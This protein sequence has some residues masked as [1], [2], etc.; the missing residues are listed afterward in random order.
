MKR[1][2]ITGVSGSNS[3]FVI[4]DLL[5]KNR[6]CLIVVSGR[7]RAE[8]LA[9]DLSFFSERR[10]LIIPTEDDVFFRY[11]AK[12]NDKEVE[13]TRVL[14][15]LLEDKESVVIV[16]ASSA[17]R[18]LPPH[19][20]FLGRGISLKRGESVEL[21]AIKESL[22]EMGYER[23][24][25]AEFPGRFA[26]RGG[27]LDIYPLDA[28]EP[29]RI[30]FF[31]TEVDSI[32]TFDP[33]S[34]RS[35]GTL[36]S[37]SINPM[38]LMSDQ[39]I[40]DYLKG[41]RPD[42]EHIW[43]YMIDGICVV[44][45]PDRIRGH[46]ELTEKEAFNDF[47][48]MLERG[49][50]SKGDEKY[51]V[52]REEL[53][54]LYQSEEIYFL[55]PFA[56]THPEEIVLTDNYSLSARPV[57]SYNGHLDVLAKDIR[58]YIADGYEVT[59]SASSE[60]RERSL[61]EFLRDNEVDALVKIR[62]GT[63]SS[64]MVLPDKKLA[65]ISESNIF[66][67]TRI[68]KKRKHPKGRKLETFAELKTGDYVVHDNHGIGI[69]IGI[70]ELKNQGEIRD[71]IKI[72]YAGHGMLYVPVDQMDVV[73][74]YIGSEGAA[75]KLNK[76]GSEEWK[77]TKARAR[78][79][80]AEMTDELVELYARRKAEKGYAFSPDTVWQQEF[81]E[82]F[83]Y[84]ETED[85]L[86]SVAEIKADMEDEEPM[87][88]L[89][90]G[91]VGYGKTE[92]AARAIFKCLVEGKQAAVLVPTT[93]LASQHYET[94]K[95][96]FKN[97]PFKIDM[98]SRF[99]S[100][101]EQ[102]KIVDALSEGKVD[103][104]I[105]THRLLSK[106]VKFDDLG[107]LVVDEEQRFGVAHKEKIKSL[108]VGVDVLTLSATPIPRTL[109]MSLT[110]I[111]DMSLITEPP[112]ERYP[113][114]TYVLEQ[115]DVLI[116]EVINREL[117]RGGQVFLVF[118]RVRG[119][120]SVADKIRSLVPDAEV[121]VAHGQMSEGTLESVMRKFIVGDINVLVATTIIESG[122]DIPNANT[123]VVLDADK[124]GLA[125][126]YQLRGRVGRSNRMAYAY[127]MYQKDKVL[128][129]L[130][131]K[132]L[133]AIKEF[134]EF[135]AGFKIAMR[136]MELRGAGNILG[137]E[138]SGHMMNVGY[139]L[140]MRLVD[141]AARK[142]RGE[143]IPEKTQDV[144]VEIKCTA[145]IPSWY[146]ENEIMKLAMYKKIADIDSQEDMSD[147]LDELI[148]RFGEVPKETN[149]L[150]KISLIRTL[151]TKAFVEKVYEQNGKIYIPISSETSIS[152]YDVFKMN[153]QYENRV[154]YH[155]GRGSYISYAIPPRD[156]K[157]D[158]LDMA[159]G[160]LS[161]LREGQKE[162]ATV[163]NE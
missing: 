72:K 27:I 148:D 30:E 144:S 98:L 25:L 35:T 37:V 153:E 52:G 34:Q 51:I 80:V 94:L 67:D 64:G 78:A 117:D 60:G 90:C 6:Q 61:R 120:I 46:L 22:V 16:P 142:A 55:Q 106:D 132:R 57:M 70:E 15:S 108:R 50:V 31:D 84:E 115:D 59:L 36:A 68:P 109:N 147:C 87:D 101:K 29:Y 135:G 127:L 124:C 121:A 97:Y 28:D 45:D 107:L 76:L 79:A 141:E 118:N 161:I 126:L 91:D 89:L 56:K 163:G 102:D 83:P 18:R 105:G 33:E 95:E 112:E 111:R 8:K 4:S 133:R 23:A 1:V 13:R 12:N 69:F 146:I 130:S 162:R 38:N 24:D 122:L 7:N 81:E 136:D 54:T 21:E 93:I 47:D 116:R 125:Q 44:D 77:R 2:S 119:I 103:L 66:N 40:E 152:A 114:Q 63:L 49:E 9:A 85:Q 48:I 62:R 158:K 128:T 104:I 129:E 53:I 65:F 157:A 150:L 10:I 42:I 139:E 41:E 43:D 149:N 113:V 96:R 88:R 17:V 26:S 75:P 58:S 154:F 11:D 110:G 143:F 39:G 99:R 82:D 73:Q 5:K 156:Y 20:L 159:I 145:N 100:D 155:E 131:E 134:T 138:Q 19:N 151:A 92:V 71:Y 137:A 140:Y 160:I 86:K 123:M 74:K 32:R 14:K 3:A